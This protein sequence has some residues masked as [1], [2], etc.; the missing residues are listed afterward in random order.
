[1]RTTQGR[2]RAG[3]PRK[4]DLEPGEGDRNAGTHHDSVHLGV[5][6]PVATEE[7]A[8]GDEHVV[9]VVDWLA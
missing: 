9:L 5:L 4:R 8:A 2:E 7:Q 1:M 3:L 6:D